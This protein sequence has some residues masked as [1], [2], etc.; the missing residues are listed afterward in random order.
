VLLLGSD[1]PGE[2]HARTDSIMIAHYDQ[3]NHQPKLISIMRDTY[4]NIPGQ[5]I[6]IGL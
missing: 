2:E 4:I 1:T 6:F 5:S 3:E